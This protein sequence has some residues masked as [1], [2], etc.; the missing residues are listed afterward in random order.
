MINGLGTSYVN[1]NYHGSY[2]VLRN[3]KS[4]DAF[5][6]S[7]KVEGYGS[8]KNKKSLF[9]FGSV[10]I[11]E[12]MVTAKY[13]KGIIKGP[14][15]SLHTSGWN[16]SGNYSEV[17]KDKLNQ[18]KLPAS[19]DKLKESN[20]YYYHGRN[21][22]DYELVQIAVA[23]GKMEMPSDQ[24]GRGQAEKNVYDAFNLLVRDEA[25]PKYAGSS[26]LYSEDGKYTFTQTANGRLSM[27]LIDDED[28]GASLDDIANWMMSGT[29][30]RN[31]ETR[32]LNYLRMVD[33]DLFDMAMRIGTEVRNNGFME[34]LH[35]QGI[36]S[37]AQSHYDM[38]LL[39]VMFGKKSE[40]MRLILN[41]CK[42]TGN[43]LGLLDIYDRN[44]AK[45]LRSLREKQYKETNGGII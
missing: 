15:V 27:H 39:G 10:T 33:P 17:S 40:D 20:R 5:P 37:D 13:G 28:V 29:P 24:E 26:T 32:Y 2:S 25:K 22:S 16:R 34:D 44:G 41:D 23:T 18:I 21:V 3:E 14:R 30:N 4:K 35:A 7:V 12:H 36:L 45:S 1:F 11:T 19:Y 9:N 42:K 43:Y 38:G 8:T 31:I 6:Y